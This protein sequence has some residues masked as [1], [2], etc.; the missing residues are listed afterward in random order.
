ME[1]LATVLAVLGLG[2]L[3]L[4]VLTHGQPGQPAPAPGP[5]AT[6][7][8]PSSLQG[9]VI[10]A[11]INP[12][13]INHAIFGVGTDSFKTFGDSSDYEQLKKNMC[14]CYN[15]NGAACAAA[16][17]QAPGLPNCR[18][19]TK[20]CD[21]NPVDL[22]GR[23]SFKTSRDHSGGLVTPYGPKVP[24]GG[25]R[26]FA[27]NGYDNTNDRASNISHGYCAGLV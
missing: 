20:D 16:L 13:S 12:N 14:N 15:G 21:C 27:A 4:W 19:G 22:G 9:L 23:I 25:C 24:V 3:A 1:G 10:Q 7:A 2:G 11:I 6:A 17:E 8:K 18:P 5:A 26:P